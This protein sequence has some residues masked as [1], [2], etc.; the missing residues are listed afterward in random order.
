MEET[1]INALMSSEIGKVLVLL[2]GGIAVIFGVYK[3]VTEIKKIYDMKIERKTTEAR[4]QKEFRDK[5]MEAIENDAKIV[6]SIEILSGR[7]ASLNDDFNSFRSETNQTLTEIQS[8]QKLYSEE[9]GTLMESDKEAIKAY[10]IEQYHK[11]YNLKYIDI[12]TLECIEKRYEKYLK[13][14]GNT[15]ISILMKRLRSLPSKYMIDENTEGDVNCD[16]NHD[17]D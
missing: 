14:N 11:Y 6:D 15:F 12:Y 13:E 9:I 10:I 4:D 16:M 2:A 17:E 3:T 1:F 5:F 7:I 8:K